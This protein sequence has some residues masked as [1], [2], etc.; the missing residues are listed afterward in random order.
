MNKYNWS[1]DGENT[2]NTDSYRLAFADLDKK[3]RID[4]STNNNDDLID[5]AYQIIEPLYKSYVTNIYSN[6]RAFAALRS[7]GSVITWGNANRGGNSSEVT[8]ENVKEIYSTNSTFATHKTDS[9][10]IIWGEG[11]LSDDES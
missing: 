2:S 10:I 3:I 7:D 1:I 4:V 6:V 5:N 9:S 8:L 11:T